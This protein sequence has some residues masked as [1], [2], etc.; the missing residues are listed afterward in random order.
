MINAHF[1]LFIVLGMREKYTNYTKID[2]KRI[3]L[4]VKLTHP[5]V[6][7][8]LISAQKRPASATYNFNFRKIITKD[9][10]TL[11]YQ[12]AAMAASIGLP[13]DWHYE[14]QKRNKRGE[15]GQNRNKRTKV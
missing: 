7:F 10:T 12:P 5:D 8:F 13:S 4:R 6:S 9:P 15:G 11:C 14:K 3:Y 1:I 2:Y